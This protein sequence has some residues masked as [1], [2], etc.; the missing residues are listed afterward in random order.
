MHP[1]RTK[2]Q[3]GWNLGNYSYDNNLEK[4]VESNIAR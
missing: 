2:T 3:I 1:I 4:P